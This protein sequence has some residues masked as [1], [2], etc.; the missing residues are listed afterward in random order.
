MRTCNMKNYNQFQYFY[1]KLYI[2]MYQKVWSQNILI[3][4]CLIQLQFNLIAI[5]F[6]YGATTFKQL[7]FLII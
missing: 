7:Y 2:L 1:R 5:I 3:F 4:K 6:E